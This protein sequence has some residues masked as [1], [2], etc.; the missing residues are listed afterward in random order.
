MISDLQKNLFRT[1]GG[2]VLIS[3]SG[4]FVRLADVEPLRSAFLRGFYALP[5]LWALAWGLRARRSQS[6]RGAFMPVALLAGLFLGADLMVWHASLGMIGAGLGTVLPNLQVV[7]VA[8]VGVLLF[9]ERPLATLWL[10]LPIV[11]VGVWLLSVTGKPVETGASVPLGVFLGVATAVFYSGYILILRLARTRRPDMDTFST[12]ASATL[13]VALST[14]IIAATQGEAGP[15]ATWQ[16]NG[17]LIAL[18]LGS[19][20]IGWGLLSSSI[21]LLPATLTAVTLLL[22]PVLALIWGAVLLSEPIG[23]VQVA[24]AAVVL[25]G[26]AMAHHAVTAGQRAAARAAA[27]A[28]AET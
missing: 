9:K 5:V 14:G 18:A 19:Q 11:L 17:W 26:V 7:V 6:W 22:Q 23:L 16:A 4:V 1:W 27:E 25:A 3:F 15:A 28:E 21:H 24:G 13:G 10:S 8:V 2:V 12:M 20:V